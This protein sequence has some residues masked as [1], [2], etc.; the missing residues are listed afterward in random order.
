MTIHVENDGQSFRMTIG[1]NLKVLN[2]EYI[3]MLYY[4]TM[5]LNFNY[6][7]DI[8]NRPRKYISPSGSKTVTKNFICRSHAK[9]P[10]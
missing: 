6:I 1:F 7:L 4:K 8:T 9:P 2:K 5:D 10:A 3:M